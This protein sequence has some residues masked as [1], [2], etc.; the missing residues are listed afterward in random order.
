ML[1]VSHD[2][3][4][5][6]DVVT[7]LLAIERDGR[8]K[9]YDGGYDDYLRQQQPEAPAEPKR[10]TATTAI[11][12][13]ERPRKR[14]HQEKRELEALPG[15]IEELEAEMQSW[16]DAMADPAFYRKPGGEI[17]QAKARLEAV[18]QEL[19]TAYQRWETLEEVGG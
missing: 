10:M 7:S 9:E 13:V 16:H 12:Q 1:L 17:A 4:F 2:R 14:S 11:R 5:L 6:N 19:T 15:R 18:E 3:A 8:V